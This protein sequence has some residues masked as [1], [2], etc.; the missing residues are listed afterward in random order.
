MPKRQYSGVHFY[1]ALKC[2]RNNNPDLAMGWIIQGQ[3]LELWEYPDPKTLVE[4][5]VGDGHKVE[6]VIEYETVGEPGPPE[7]PRGSLTFSV[8]T[9]NL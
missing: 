6:R 8:D 1:P 4:R 9:I 7:Q 2:M 5:I 3:E